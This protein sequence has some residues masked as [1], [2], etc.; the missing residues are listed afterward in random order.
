MWNATSVLLGSFSAQN[1]FVCLVKTWCIHRA[2]T[3][4]YKVTRFS[5]RLTTMFTKFLEIHH[6]FCQFVKNHQVLDMHQIHQ[7]FTSCSDV[8]P[9]LG[10]QSGGF[11]IASSFHCSDCR[12]VILKETF[13]GTISRKKTQEA[14]STLS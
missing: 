3:R 1:A 12:Y 9:S 7:V 10:D 13:F 6:V 4:F 5:P 8:S 14:F 11:R 2:F